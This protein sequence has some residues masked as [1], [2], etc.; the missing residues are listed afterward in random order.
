MAE[1]TIVSLY[2]CYSCGRLR[3]NS[4]IKSGKRCK[5]GG[6]RMIKAPPTVMNRIRYLIDN[7]SMIKVWYKEN[8]KRN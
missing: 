6:G 2:R 8:V 4:E 7:P 3:F 1:N 5:C